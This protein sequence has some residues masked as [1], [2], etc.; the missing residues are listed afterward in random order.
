[1]LQHRQCNHDSMTS[2]LDLSGHSTSSFAKRGALFVI[3]VLVC[4]ASSVRG[5]AQVLPWSQRVA[6]SVMERWP[7]GYRGSANEKPARPIE[8]G[9]LLSG[10]DAA[11]YESAVGDYYHYVKRLADQYVALDRSTPDDDL[12]LGRQLLLLYRVTQDPKYYKAANRL[13]G[14]L[15]TRLEGSRTGMEEFY[16]AEPFYAEYSSVFQ[17]PTNFRDITEQFV[18][19]EQRARSFADGM[20]W[21]M[22]ALV[23]SLEF[24]PSKDPSRGT[25]LTI[26]DRTA[27]AAILHRN[28]S[29]GLW[30]QAHRETAG[31]QTASC[32]L[33][34]SLQR[35]VR[36][37]Y[38][39]QRYSQDARRAWRGVTSSLSLRGVSDDPSEAG[40]CLLAAT[41]IEMGSQAN[42]V[43]GEVVLIDSWFNSQQRRS[44]SGQED[45]F[46]YKWDD[47]SDSGF[48][49]LGHIFASHG[50]TLAALDQ[51]P[52]VDLLKHASYYIIA[53]PDIPI[54]NPH[55]NYMERKDAAEIAKWVE[56][57]GILVLMPNDPAN[58]DI[59][60]L[61]L[62]ADKFGIHFDKALAHHVIGDQ[63]SPGL[64]PVTGTGAI[65]SG[66]H[67]L[68]MKDTC[69]IS[70]T[71]SARSLL[72]DE[73]G[74]VIAEAK[75]GKG[76]V[77]AVIDPWLYNEYTDHRKVLPVQDNFAAGEEFIDWL[78]KQPHR[79][80]T[81]Q[82]GKHEA[83]I[84]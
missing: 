78:L 74:V 56:G 66:P 41:E 17:E 4:L 1:M 70:L 72:S 57:G 14:E 15:A 34:Y 9:I 25:L 27:K 12:A 75:Y 40:A 32:I 58:G 20:G 68:Y 43:R 37:G 80:T 69:T 63:F 62:L 47:Y 18:S 2:Y 73:T 11:W 61:D 52:T 36:M 5:Q 24:Y 51:A 29:E 82:P 31:S 6:N 53:S 79:A 16:L 26:L 46:H 44:A 10:M 54:K 13:R 8:V 23:D 42:Q 84:Q 49:L 38:L 33:I 21:Y 59:D 35:G 76:T 83:G 55:P 22:M 3:A 71:G 50:A 48:S 81:Q 60:H 64:I 39:R 67:T 65:F 30:P 7:D 28:E 19:T 45:Y 77:V